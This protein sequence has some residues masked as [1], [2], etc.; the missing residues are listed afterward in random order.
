MQKNKANISWPSTFFA[1]MRLCIKCRANWIRSGKSIKFNLIKSIALLCR[2]ACAFLKKKAA[3]DNIKFCRKREHLASLFCFACPPESDSQRSA[4]RCL[5]IG[6]NQ[7]QGATRWHTNNS[8]PLATS[9][10]QSAW[11]HFLVTIPSLGVRVPF[12]SVWSFPACPRLTKWQLR[13]H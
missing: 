5:E 12:H 8:L 1:S 2:C 13:R 10:T 3:S 7:L 9:V 4:I 11:G 6:Y